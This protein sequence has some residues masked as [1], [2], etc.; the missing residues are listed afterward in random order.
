MMV[1]M[2]DIAKEAGVSQSTVSLVLG[3]KNTSIKIA[4]R[5]KEKVLATIQRLGYRRN[6]LATSMKT[7]RTNMIGFIGGLDGEYVMK[8]IAGINETL[9]ENGYLLKLLGMKWQENVDRV[10]RQCV[11]QRLDGVI[12][13]SLDETQLQLL[14]QELEPYNIPVVLVDN[15]FSHDWCPRVMS[16]DRMGTV[17]AVKH[18]AQLG[19]T[20][21]GYLSIKNLSGFVALRKEGFE[22]GMK[23]CGLEFSDAGFSYIDGVMDVT[24]DTIRE[25]DRFYRDFHPSAIV[26]V[27][28][29]VAMKLL[30]WAYSR[31]IRIPDEL[32]VTGFASLDYT[33]FSAPALTTV[34]QPFERMGMVAAAKLLDVIGG[35]NSSGDEL[36]PVEL[37]IRASTAK[38]HI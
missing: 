18:L 15:S 37:V 21:I 8:I 11:E 30:Q 35:G 4:D 32:S 31:H 38:A 12:C 22:Q 14:R 19:H 24:E 25:L 29:P 36:L 3:N 5:T 20:R 13:R 10:A 33:I 7:G 34:N 17:L 9:A 28:D 16:N 23:A 27:S 1:T 2:K 6:E 26:C